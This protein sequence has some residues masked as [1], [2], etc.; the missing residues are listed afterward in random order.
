MKARAF[1]QRSNS[2]EGRNSL[3]KEKE[4][5]KIQEGKN[6]ENSFW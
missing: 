4:R 6:E 5:N 3:N 2:G 1:W